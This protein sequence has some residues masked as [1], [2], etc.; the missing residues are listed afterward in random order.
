MKRILSSLVAFFLMLAFSESHSQTYLISEGGIVQTCSGEF[1]D[2][3]G[4]SGNY[5]NNEDYTMTFYP[6]TS[7][8]KL[9]FIFT[10]FDIE[11]HPNCNWDNLRIYDGINA[12]A[13]LIGSYCGTNSPGL[14]LATS[15]SG[16]L[17]FRF[18]SNRANNAPGWA[19][20]ISCVIPPTLG[21]WTGATSS[22]WNTPTNWYNNFVPTS[23]TDVTIP[24]AA[25]NWPVY[26]GDLSVGTACNDMAMDG[27]SELTVTGN[28]TV[29]EGKTF[30][31][32]GSSYV[33]IG[34]DF[35]RS[36]MFYPGTGTI[37]FYGSSST[38]ISGSPGMWAIFKDGF[39]TDKG[40]TLTGEFERGVP[41]GL[42][43][44]PGIN[45]NPDPTYAYAGMNV[46]GVDLTGLG[47][48]PG[49]Y[50][51]NLG[52]QE[53][54]AISP[55][56]NCA[57][58]TNVSF[59]FQRWLGVQNFNQD[60]A[61]I[62]VSIDGGNT[63]INVWVHSTGISET[64]WSYQAINISAY[65]DNQPDVRVRFTMGP[66]NQNQGYCG[67]NIDE[68]QVMGNVADFVP[69]YNLVIHKDNAEVI[70]NAFVEV[71]NNLTVKPNAYLTNTANR[72]L[73]VG[74]DA[75]FE[76]GA[77]G[78]A[79][80]IDNGT[81]SVD[82][83]T[84]V[85]QYL[86]SERW[87]MVSPPITD[88]IINTYFD[89]YLRFYNEPDN[90][91]TYLILPV[92]IP[93]DVAAGYSAWASN[94]LT[95][96]TTV[97][98]ETFNGMLNN[99][100]YY[101]D[102]LS[103]TPGAPLEGFNLLG[104]PYISALEWSSN[105]YMNNLSGWMLIWDDG[106]YRGYHTDGTTYND[107]TP[108]IPSTQGFWI[109]ALNANADITIPKSE[110]VHN[111]QAFY[112]GGNTTLLPEIRLTSEINGLTDE[113]AIF[114]RPD[115]TEG[116]DG[117]Y[118][119]GK[120]DNVSEAP[121]LFTISDG[122][123]YAVKCLED[124]FHE[125][126]IPVGFKTGEE[127]IFTVHASRVSGFGTDIKIYLEDKKMGTIIELSENAMV[128]FAYSTS[129]DPHRF[130]ILF[131]DTAIGSEDISLSD[132]FIY[133]FQNIV[134]IR[135]PDQQSGE[136]AIYDLMGREITRN[137]IQGEQLNQIEVHSSPGYYLVRVMTADK[138]VTQKVFI[139]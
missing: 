124:K 44:G 88:A 104:N 91:W 73:G 13:P 8:A 41:L 139:R 12:G 37:E 101:I 121:T 47:D 92:T 74:G 64:E 19:A 126:T 53:Y 131:K 46:L 109:R 50:E 68:F 118:D 11:S 119:L 97:E 132:V 79:S 135:I 42:G 89:I 24:S 103:F 59:N 123:N 65:A 29:S 17:T 22:D 130:N 95:G 69:L 40:W 75:L 18:V 28:F 113:T 34:G 96:T 16:A 5:A 38:T 87:H 39:E 111:D 129:D 112:K 84:T 133:S 66:T 127:G 90:T 15:T 125:V 27:N 7:G 128:E 54:Q 117:Y 62:D 82:G 99:S 115:A 6:A 36:G 52:I 4:P 31:S 85:Q 81:F 107:G 45:N 3:G 58:I 134:N 48:F 63:W 1:Y 32:T 9:Q 49:N 114:F 102:T 35:H 137:T 138:V 94:S 108:I 51:P 23:I 20:T 77:S 110:R 72:I 67:W 83:A 136:A 14:V 120:F 57:N 56:F 80:F 116:F 122:I 70:S 2:S 33:R 71:A 98:F 55:S 30:T 78:M 21:L 61:H 26:P 76:A 10:A 25:A 93:M 60:E 100:D 86:T 105:W 43:G 106:I